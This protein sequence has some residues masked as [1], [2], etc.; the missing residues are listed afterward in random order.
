MKCGVLVNIN[1]VKGLSV[2]KNDVCVYH[3]FNK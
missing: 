3:I 1:I 2:K